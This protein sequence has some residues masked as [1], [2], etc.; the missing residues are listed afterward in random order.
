MT[1]FF[2]VRYKLILYQNIW[3]NETHEWKNNHNKTKHERTSYLL[4]YKNM[5]IYK[6]IYWHFAFLSLCYLLRGL[7]QT[8]EIFGG[9]A[10]NPGALPWVWNSR[11]Y[12]TIFLK[13]VHKR[14]RTTRYWFSCSIR[15]QP[16]VFSDLLEVEHLTQGIKKLM[17]CA[18]MAA[19]FMTTSSVSMCI[20]DG[21]S[22]GLRR[23][24]SIDDVILTD[25]FPYNDVIMSA[26]ASQ[27]TSLTSVYSTVYSRRR[28]KKTSKIRVTGLCA[29]NS[30]VNG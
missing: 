23:L 19:G 18:R 14:N 2:V 3:L 25:L 10:V 16:W 30:S 8:V 12:I 7:N 6:G 22:W 5:C 1:C 13:I 29:G 27:I 17:L 24:S 11:I 9:V 28:S 4:H 15:M 20:Q 21:Y 26:M